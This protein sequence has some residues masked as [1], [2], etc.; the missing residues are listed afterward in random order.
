MMYL[1]SEVV[2]IFPRYSS[3]VEYELLK[4]DGIL[5]TVTGRFGKILHEKNAF[6]F[7]PG[8]FSKRFC[9]L[10]QQTPSEFQSAIMFWYCTAR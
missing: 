3:C 4:F 9:Q 8:I 2:Y 1:A 7:P 5:G 6:L 10:Y